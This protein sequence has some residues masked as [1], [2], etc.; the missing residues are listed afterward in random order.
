[1]V[2]TLVLGTSAERRVGSS[3]T[4]G[5]KNKNDGKKRKGI[6]LLTQMLEDMKAKKIMDET[7]N[8]YVYNRIRKRF[9]EGDEISCSRCRYHHGD[10]LDHKLYGDYG[11]RR[12]GSLRQPNWKLV[13]KNKK[14]WMDKK[15]VFKIKKNW[16]WTFTE[17]I[18]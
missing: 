14:Q 7:T 1:M 17:I 18:F 6:C 10:N 12:N 8:R 5:T 16:S 4:E 15:L 11:S 3:P 2:D 9:L 13:S